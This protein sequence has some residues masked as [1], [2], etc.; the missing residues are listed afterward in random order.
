MYTVTDQNT[1]FTQSDKDRLQSNSDFTNFK[2]K[3]DVKIRTLFEEYKSDIIDAMVRQP[4]PL[5]LPHEIQLNVEGPEDLMADASIP[6]TIEVWPQTG[7]TPSD[8]Y[9]KCGMYYYPHMHV[10]RYLFLM[11]PYAALQAA[12]VMDF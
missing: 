12:V 11:N 3:S 10:P 9:L 6:N 7:R 5:D 8:L 2:T 1:P 4:R